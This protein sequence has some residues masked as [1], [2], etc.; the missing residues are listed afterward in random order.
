MRHI[1]PKYHIRGDLIVKTSNNDPVPDDEPLI[2][3]RG[4]DRLALPM[5]RAYRELCVAD[6]CTTYQMEG[7]DNRISAFETFQ[8][9]QAGRMKQPGATKGK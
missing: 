3:F 5:L 9:K 1:D 7:I 4:R 2:L 6:G 8:R